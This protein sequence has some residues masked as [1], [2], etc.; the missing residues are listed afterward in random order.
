[1]NSYFPMSLRFDNK[2]VLMI[3]G[4]SIAWFKFDKLIQFKPQN[5]KC[6]A[7]NFNE[8][9]KTFR[10]SN[11][12]NQN[13]NIEYFERAYES[14]DLDDADMVI[15]AI[16]DAKLQRAIYDECKSKKILCNC[17]DLLDC[18]DFIFPSIVRRGNI[19][20]A[21]NSNGMLP[22]FSAVLRKY[23][24][25]TMPEGIEEAF[26]ELV[27]MRKSLAPGPSRMKKIRD[28]AQKYF[29]RLKTNNKL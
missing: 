9:F 15:V 3:G 13:S 18:C 25:E 28:E 16:D 19:T 29:D 12:H 8:D 14:R 26:L 20:V 4:G 17:V 7:I 22:G 21:I 10:E 5:L 2:R 11:V 23:F 24:D 6:V 27:E 1:M